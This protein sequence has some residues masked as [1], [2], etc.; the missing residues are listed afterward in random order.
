MKPL[1]RMTVGF[2]LALAIAVFGAA[3]TGRALPTPGGIT[4]L[5]LAECSP[6]CWI[7]ITPGVSTVADA[8]AKILAAFGELRI[9]DT[10]GFPGGYVSDTTVDNE[11][12][13][14]NFALSVRL[15]TSPPVDGR[16]E[17]IRAITLMTTRA[18]HISYAPTVEDILAVFGAPGGMYIDPSVNGLREIT[19]V[20]PG[21]AV[22]FTASPGQPGFAQNPRLYLRAADSE[23]AAGTFYRWAGLGALMWR[24]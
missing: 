21:L 14:D 16:S 1:L 2:W 22:A 23:R 12:T 5:R 20:Y 8:K 15:T 6:P 17:I 9:R 11:I 7:G 4:R 13:G 24:M 10:A 18:D 3:L 19:L